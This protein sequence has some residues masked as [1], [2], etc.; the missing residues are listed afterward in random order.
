M[1]LTGKAPYVVQAL[2]DPAC[3]LDSITLEELVR[4]FR[5]RA[6][7]EGERSSAS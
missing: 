4:E 5:Q 3:L 1:L 6:G 2:V 7:A